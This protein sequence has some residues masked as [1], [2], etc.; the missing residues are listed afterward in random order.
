MREFIASCSKGSPLKSLITLLVLT[1]FCSAVHASETDPSSPGEGDKPR[2][3]LWEV[4]VEGNRS[5]PQKDLERTIYYHLGPDKTIDDIEALRKD[6][7][8]L[9]HDSGFGVVV[10]SVPPQDTGKGV[11]VIQVTEGKIEQVKVSGTRY[12]SPEAI[13]QEVEAA[14]QGG[15]LNLT[16]FQ[17]ELATANTFSA[18]RTVRPILRPGKTPGTVE[19]ELKVRDELPLHGSLELNNAYTAD[20]THLRLNAG[21]GYYNLWQRG[22]SLSFQYQTAPENRDEVDVLSTNY[23]FR[24]PDNNITMVIYNVSSKSNTVTAQGDVTVVG[25]GDI[26]GVRAIFPLAESDAA[27]SQSL[28]VGVDYKSFEETIESGGVIST[29]I[30][31]TSFAFS[32]NA[33]GRLQQQDILSFGVTAKVAPHAL[34]NTGKEFENKRA[35]ASPNFAYLKGNISYT[36]AFSESRQWL[37]KGRINGQLSDAPLISNEQ[38]GIGGAQSVRGYFESQSLGDKGVM[39]SA[40]LYFP[41]LS[42]SF[43]KPFKNFSSYLFADG[44]RVSSIDTLPYQVSVDTIAGIG[45]GLSFSVGKYISSRFEFAQAILPSGSIGASNRVETGDVRSHFVVKATF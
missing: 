44:G 42:P 3:D 40:E 7:E 21:I 32:Y 4:R 16:S 33:G 12:F 24:L 41:Q 18:D 13:R 1:M 34:G 36:H 19:V 15:E 39:A 8:R 9:Y 25:N 10:V 17:E 43:L 22:H 14:H 20:S 38:F 26:T 5:L 35:F 27:F 37:L 23:A 28:G 45:I 30:S 6:I 11:V 31:Y 2:F 29:P